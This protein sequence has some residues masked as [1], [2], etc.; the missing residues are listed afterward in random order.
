MDWHGYNPFQVFNPF[1]KYNPKNINP[2]YWFIY[3]FFKFINY[4]NYIKKNELG[5]FGL[6]AS[7]V[8]QHGIDL[9]NY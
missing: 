9:F 3:I 2:N 4:N 8:G 5:H 7:Q 6:F 1:K